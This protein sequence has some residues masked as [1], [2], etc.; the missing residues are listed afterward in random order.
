MAVD[1]I[2]REPPKCVDATR[3]AQRIELTV[4][5]LPWREKVTRHGK[6]RGTEK[7]ERTA[8]GLVLVELDGTKGH[9]GIAPSEQDS[10]KR[11]H[12]MSRQNELHQHTRLAWLLLLLL[13]AMWRLSRL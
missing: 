6:D 8:G 12:N 2:R 5:D 13:V 11:A 10:I 7:T 9:F 4:N 1:T 3:V